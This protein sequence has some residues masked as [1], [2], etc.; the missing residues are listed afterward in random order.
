[1]DVYYNVFTPNLIL[2][3]LPHKHIFPHTRVH[4]CTGARTQKHAL[5]IQK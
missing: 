1:M 3:K 5:H 4:T 2:K